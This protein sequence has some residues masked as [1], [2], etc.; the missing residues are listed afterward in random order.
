MSVSTID[1]NS[2]SDLINNW[3]SGAN[4][5][6]VTSNFTIGPSNASSFPLLY[7]S[8]NNVSFSGVYQQSPYIITIDVG[9]AVNW[10]G[11]FRF[12]NTGYQMT[13]ENLIIQVVSANL[14]AGQS[15]ILAQWTS[16]PTI[17]IE[18][19]QV[20]IL[21]TTPSSITYPAGTWAGFI[22]ALNINVTGTT[23]SCTN[24]IY[25]GFTTQNAGGY[26]ATGYIGGSPPVPGICTL[27][28]TGCY[29]YISNPTSF[30][31][32]CAGFCGNQ[33]RLHNTT[34]SNCIVNLAAINPANSADTI[35]AFF[36]SQCSNFSISNSYVIISDTTS[37]CNVSF[38]STEVTTDGPCSVNNCYFVINNSTSGTIPVQTLYN[39]VGN[40][41]S[42][43]ISNS[44][45]QNGT[46]YNTPSVDTN[47]I[48]NYYYDFANLLTSI[49]FS[50]WD[51]STIWSTSQTTN[52]PLILQVFENT[53]FGGYSDSSDVPTM[54]NLCIFEG[55]KIL[56]TEGY[57]PVEDI[58]KNHILCTWNGHTTTIKNILMFRNPS[59]RCYRIPVDALAPSIPHEDVYLTGGHAI[60]IEENKFLHPMHMMGKIGF[61]IEKRKCGQWGKYRHYNIETENYEK[62]R[63]IAS[64]LPIEG[65]GGNEPSD[66]TWQC[67]ENQECRYIRLTDIVC[68]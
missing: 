6:R 66:H 42:L 24:C 3:N 52:T 37:I 55:A 7:S 20:S 41:G 67:I 57:I 62:D 26:V 46:N 43:S 65:F 22:C 50:G 23:I 17:Q 28:F 39:F 48:T 9:S 2:A 10:S 38:T 40:G 27:T 4:N 68:R 1:V 45:F 13:F 21:P 51:L 60:Y 15:A 54:S 53:P 58:T 47:N 11:I 33:M 5:I 63:L 29:S 56:T 30:Q 8:T 12:A 35:G 36:S 44:A 32:T 34:I 59:V 25:E 31:T 49:P 16:N 64:G 61:P 14:V 18:N 19:V